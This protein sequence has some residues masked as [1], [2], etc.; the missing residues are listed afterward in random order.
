MFQKLTATLGCLVLCCA[1]YGQ[2]GWLPPVPIS[3][4][5]CDPA[6][7][8]LV[9]YDEFN[10]TRID[11][12]KWKTYVTWDG[13]N[14]IRNGVSILKPDHPDW[15]DARQSYKTAIFK[16]DNVVVSDGTCKL[17]LKNDPNVTWHY[18]D[19]TEVDSLTG[20]YFD[21]TLVRNLSGGTIN[22]PYLKPDGSPNYYNSGRFEAQIKFP[23]FNGAW[24]CFWLWFGNTVN[25]LDMAESWGGNA[26]IF[27]LWQNKQHTDYA[28]HSWGP[29]E[30]KPNPYGLPGEIDITSHY[31]QQNWWNYVLGN[32]FDQQ[33]W[34]TYAYEWD[35]ASINIYLDHE[36]LQTIWKYSREETVWKWEYRNGHW[37]TYPFTYLVG[38][39]CNPDPG[40]WNIT[41][42][43]PYN[44]N[45][46]QC[47]LRL[48]ASFDH[49]AQKQGETA[50]K[51]GQME[52][53]YV[54]VWQKHP[55]QDGHTDLCSGNVVPAINGPSIVCNTTAYNISPVQPGGIWTA[56][57]DAVIFG[58]GTQ[59][60][61]SSLIYPNPNSQYA[62]TILSYTYQPATPGCP[63]IT[64]SKWI[65]TSLSGANITCSRNRGLFTQNFTLIASPQLTGATY[66]WEI[67]Y[68]FSSNNLTHY[69]ATGPVAHTPSMNH[70]G[71]FGYY[72]KWKLTITTACGQKVTTG[73][74]NNFS[75]VAPS[76]ARVSTFME[77]DSS[78][79]YLETR[80]T[81]QDSI[82]YNAAVHSA[83]ARSMFADGTDTT[84]VL[85][86]I[87]KAKAQALEPYLYFEDHVTAMK[88]G[89]SLPATA[90]ESCLYPNP[91]NNILYIKPGVSFG[92][93]KP[94]DITIHDLAG[95]QILTSAI[96]YPKGNTI[97]IDI[98]HLAAGNYIVTLLQ[99][100]HTE[101][102]KLA[103][104]N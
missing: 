46:S 63:P 6:P 59:S 72:V 16:D 93:D 99:D 34:H 89:I 77:P 98:S 25:E 44:S 23:T 41:V 8:K 10:G 79:V 66:S 19:S 22:T 58:G 104:H 64:V 50:Y 100:K 12:T 18:V 1:L 14:V 85:A 21:S 20:A 78:A 90:S 38:S 31:P 51:K 37:D 17:I 94:I 35:T 81:T 3:G 91:A 33:N 47:Q 71:I 49:V 80:F 4:N 62:S 96:S 26:S 9:F 74:K 76:L 13:M 54:K 5:A 65:Q 40:L 2:N 43:Y 53:E 84:E 95:K 45:N 32:N 57:N 28:M 56:S 70:W 68:G 97:T 103:K 73:H 92:Q 39:T 30:N 61:S 82:Q 15:G 42:G 7:W 29:G 11:S 87:E 67:D 69:T 52:I 27:N 83:V 36:W 48:N 101:H 24:C 86:F 55:E 102:H 88:S 60:G 75:Y